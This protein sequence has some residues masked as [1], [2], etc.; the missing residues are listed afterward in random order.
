MNKLLEHIEKNPQDTKRLI[1]LTSEQFKSLVEAGEKLHN[2]KQEEI[3]SSKKRIIGAGGGRPPKLS[4]QEQI[5][6]TLVYLRHLPTFQMLGI[7]FDIS[8]S[9]ANYIFH[10][11]IEIFRELLPSSLLE[12]VEKSENEEEWVK[13]ILSELELIVD[14]FEQ[15][16]E[17]PKEYQ[18]QKKY[19]SG[20]K[21]NYTF[22]GQL[23]ATS[24]GTDIVDIEVG[25]PG[26]IS[27]INFWREQQKKLDEKQKFKGDK[28]YQGEPRI[29]TPKKKPKNQELSPEIKADNR[30]KSKQ[31]IFVEHLIRL[32]KIFRVASERFRLSAKNY[33]KVVLVVCGLVRLRIGTIILCM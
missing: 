23:I 9:A 17:R 31:R 4:N 14:S 5:L 6:L 2:Q 27:D 3:A 24:N 21:K 25:K 30:Q 33:E 12:Q 32:L 7:Q 1:G 11:W 20:K 26:P 15:P 28:A 22:K 19:Y 13:E 16:R 8:E 10:Y 18:E 29:D